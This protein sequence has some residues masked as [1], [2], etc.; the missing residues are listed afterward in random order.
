LTAPAHITRRSFLVAALAA[1][2]GVAFGLNASGSKEHQLDRLP[3]AVEVNAWV[4]VGPDNVVTIKIPQVELGQ[5]TLTTITQLLAEELRLHPDLI[6]SELY[7]PTTNILRDNVY[8]WTPTL[9][10]LSAD[11]LF[12][13]ARVGAAQVR[14]M[15]LQAA[16]QRFQTEAR[17]LEVADA[18]IRHPASGRSCQF[19]QLAS[20]AAKLPIPSADR[21]EL[22]PRAQWRY[23]GVALPRRDSHA[24][25]NGSAVYGIDVHMPGMKYA[26]VRQC[27]IFQ[28]RLKSFEATPLLTERGIRGIFKI[29]AGR[30]GLNEPAELG[31]DD[32]GMDDAVA[33]V[34]DGWW[35]ANRAFERLPIEWE[36]GKTGT[37]NSKTL[38][39]DMR[40]ALDRGG[41]TYRAEGDLDGAL[42]ASKTVCRAEYWFPFMEHATLE[43]MN[44]T[45]LYERDRL[46]LWAPT[47]YADE[48]VRV[49]AHAVGTSVDMV[50]LHLT[51]VG[52][53][54]GRRIS[55]DYVSQAAQVAKQMP[56][57]PVKLLW[58]REETFRRGYYPQPVVSRFVGGLDEQGRLIAWHCKAVF[59]KKFDQSYAAARIAQLIPNTRVEVATVESPVPFGWMRGVGWTQFAWMTQG[60]LDELAHAAHRD[61]IEFQ[62]SLLDES[63]L[64]AA[65]SDREYAVERIRAQQ[66][67]L[68]EVSARSHWHRPVSPP[69]GR[70]VA[71]SD[72]SYWS[73]YRTSATAAVV[74]LKM[75]GQ[76]WFKVER[77]VVAIDCGVVINPDVVKAQLEGSVGWALSNALYSEITLKDGQVEQRNFNDYPVLRINEMPLVETYILESP[78]PPSGVGEDAIPVTI[79]ALVNAIAAATNVRVRSLPVAHLRPIQKRAVS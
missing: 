36:G 3:Q 75:D 35:E 33:I 22:T 44:C 77:V 8:V 17:E 32:W 26:A 76:G 16:A 14:T 39:E 55:N 28:G 63:N 54:Y 2:G 62:L 29:E 18:Q 19:A 71:V 64:P 15:L 41:L 68:K 11:R 12:V 48:A 78:A 37:F 13:A 73:G 30:A 24:K 74:E 58:S 50:K 42:S 10:S 1:G 60:F 27:P 21:V 51:Y 70:G 25:S 9:S 45:A 47:Q 5:G 66:R 7:D 20:A 43:P 34:A 38:A 67:V 31:A 6:L 79:G 57:V 65:M 40:Y 59:A 23:I 69:W 46:E 56:G 4:F 49:A 53:G 61:P 72:F 52:G